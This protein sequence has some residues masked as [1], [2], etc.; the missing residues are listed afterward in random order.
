M[1]QIKGK[2]PTTLDP[3]QRKYIFDKL[4]EIRKSCEWLLTLG[5][6]NILGNI[7]KLTPSDHILRRPTLVVIAIQMIIALIGATGK[8]YENVDP[9]QL[10]QQLRETLWWRYCIRNA[11]LGLLVIAFGMLLVQIW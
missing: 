6:V 8:L 10:E 11:S 3:E 7:L 1:S 9:A 2:P 5:A 4:A